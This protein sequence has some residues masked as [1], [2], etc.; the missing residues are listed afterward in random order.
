M[1]NAIRVG[2]LFG[3]PFYVDPSWFLIL[4][5]VTWTYGSILD[6]SSGLPGVLPWLLGLVSALLLFASVLAHELG[7]SL[8]AMR[9]GIGVRSITLFIFGGLASLEKESDSPGNAFWVAIAG[10]AVSFLLCGLLLC[11]M[12]FTEVSGALSQVIELLASI[13][14]VLG[15]FNLIPGLPL[16]G[17]NILKSLIWK[18]TGNPYSGIRI[19]SRVGQAI[20]WL[21]IAVGALS[22]LRITQFGSFWM[23][24]I[25][26]FLLQNAGRSA[27]S[28]TIQERLDGLTA[29]D[30]VTSDSP[31]VSDRISLREFANDFVI[32]KSKWRRFLVA[33]AEGFFVGTL[34]VDDLRGV[35][36]SNWP[37]VPV[38]ELTQ[39]YAEKTV[40]SDLP[41]LQ[42]IVM[43]EEQ[44]QTQLPVVRENGILVGLLEKA[45]IAQLLQ[46]DV[47]PAFASEA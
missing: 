23:L 25:G 4:G 45:A 28:A 5:L 33:D 16:D 15:T 29:A 14:F 2:S 9:Q 11:A 47:Q 31:V 42:A 44:S 41:L 26:L 19:A 7:H 46:H 22:V 36:T 12:L 35:P 38:R 34:N 27:Q 21:G 10:P 20:G 43:L 13:N 32:G 30:A 6:A 39:P 40:R 8:V 18:I 1:G 24:L 37:S 17:G 3:I